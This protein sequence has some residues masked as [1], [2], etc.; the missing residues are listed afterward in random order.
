MLL[1]NAMTDRNQQP[2][3]QSRL[4]VLVLCTGNS[5]RSI[6]AEAI[7]NSVG[8]P[9]FQAFSAGS[10]LTGKVNPLALEQIGRLTM[11]GKRVV[12]KRVVEESVAEDSVIRSKSWDE[13][14][15]PGAPEFDLVLTVCDNAAAE[16]CPT[17]AGDYTHIHWGL[18]DPAGVSPNNDIERAAFNQCFNVLYSRVEA[19]VSTLSLSSSRESIYKA[20]RK[21][22]C[23]DH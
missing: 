12:E 10:R 6:M 21:L 2:T 13:F 7:F 4:R 18:P 23:C 8:A 19:L 11:V 14:T 9:L 3:T 17:F 5:A 1:T 15:K 22:A 16:T 20:M